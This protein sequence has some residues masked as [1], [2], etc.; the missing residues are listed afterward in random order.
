MMYERINVPVFSGAICNALLNQGY[1]II[2]VARN[3]KDGTTVFYFKDTD[4]LH[5]AIASLTGTTY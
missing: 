5:N 1:T 4:E 2:S 3:Y